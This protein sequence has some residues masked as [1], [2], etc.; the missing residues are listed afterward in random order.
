MKQY[1][2]LFAAWIIWSLSWG[3]LCSLTPP[4]SVLEIVTG[5]F[6]VGGAVAGG[7]YSWYVIAEEMDI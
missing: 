4:D 7:I 1:L 6:A 5:I 2:C 3:A